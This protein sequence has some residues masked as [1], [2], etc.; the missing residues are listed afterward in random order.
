MTQANIQTA[1][2]VAFAAKETTFAT[3]PT[4][5][6][7]IIEA[8]SHDGDQNNEPL[9]DMDASAL[10]MDQKNFVDGLFA[11]SA[12]FKTKVRPFA[13]QITG[14]APATQPAAMDVLEVVLG[15]MQVGAGSAISA[16]TTSQVTVA[17]DTGFAI[18]QVVGISG[19]SDNQLA[20]VETKPGANVV[21][22]WPNVAAPVTS[23]TLVNGYSAFVTETNEKS[24][25]YQHAYPDSANEQEE[26]RGCYGK[27]KLV[28]D[29][30]ALLMAEFDLM[31]ATGQKGALSLST[32][33]QTNVLTTGGFAVKDAVLL[34]QPT[35]TTTRVSLNVHDVALE[36]D[37][38]MVFTP[39]HT[40][41]QGKDGTMRI[42]GR[43]TAKLTIKIKADSARNAEWSARTDQ[44]ILYGIPSGSGTTKRWAG[45]YA[46]KAV[47][48]REP[49]P[50]KEGGRLLYELEYIFK[51]DTAAAANSLQGA[52]VQIF[53]L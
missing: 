37:P 34:I 2:Q 51:I 7:L 32:A 35:A 25:S 24:L 42:K 33:V 53:C 23:G 16:G 19:A 13:T 49:K 27:M 50:V 8:D 46:P 38:G 28:T 52:P 17:A 44:R 1:K 22:F 15:G 48:A 9:E 21:T 26:Y 43:G 40:G 10:N 29:L 47:L 45:F 39:S 36:F 6:A 20:V 41:T 18:G 12:K 5:K 14:A 31:P 30:N 3:L 11:G 4:M